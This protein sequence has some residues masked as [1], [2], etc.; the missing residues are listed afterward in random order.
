MESYKELE[1]KLKTINKDTDMQSVINTC[2]SAAKAIEKLSA[3]AQNGESA[4]D[5]SK[6]LAEKVEKMQNTIW[7][8]Q[9]LD[10]YKTDKIKELESAINIVNKLCEAYKKEN[11][12]Q[13]KK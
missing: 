5:T 4:I 2:Y 7:E 6:R 13:K 8:L 11:G 12:E 3:L 9:E 1:K 10:K